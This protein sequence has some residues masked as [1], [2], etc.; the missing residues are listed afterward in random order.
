MDKSSLERLRCR[1]LCLDC[2]H[3][4]ASLR[5]AELRG[6]MGPDDWRYWVREG[7]EG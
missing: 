7:E 2:L 4:W 3:I 5:M 1:P 6:Y